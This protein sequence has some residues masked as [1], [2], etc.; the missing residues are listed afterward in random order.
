MAKRWAAMGLPSLP[1]RTALPRCSRTGAWFGVSKDA[2]TT[3]ARLNAINPRD[4]EAWRR[5]AAALRRRMR[6][7]SSACSAMKC[8][9]GRR[10]RVIWKAWRQNG[11]AWTLDMLRF[12]T[13]PTRT[14]ADAHFA[15]P[16]VK[17]TLAAWGMHLDFPPDVAGGALFP[18]LEVH[19]QPGLRHGDRQ[20][21]R[22]HDDQ[23]DD[24]LPQGTGRRD[25]SECAG[26]RGHP[27]RRAAPAASGSPMA[28]ASRRGAR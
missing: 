8:R 12:L 13:M 19:D 23:G 2:E 26:G 24:G 22:R 21:R 10:R 28:A 6:R 11:T 15:D 25:P 20:G 1:P 16:R 17:A 18:Y 5:D 14:W 4:A 9:P 7:I 27:V 3:L